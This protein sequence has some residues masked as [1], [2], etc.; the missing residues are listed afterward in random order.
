MNWITTIELGNYLIAHPDVEYEC[1]MRIGCGIASTHWWYFDS[2]HQ[3]FQHSRDI[4][5]DRVEPRE[6]IHSYKNCFWR[7]EL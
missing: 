3:C 5:Y 1:R 2:K 4:K 6:F 7:I